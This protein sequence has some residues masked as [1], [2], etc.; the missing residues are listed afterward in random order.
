MERRFRNAHGLRRYFLFL[1]FRLTRIFELYIFNKFERVFVLSEY[2]RSYLLS[3]D[4][5]LKVALLRHSYGAH[6]TNTRYEREDQSLL[7]LGAMDRGP[8]VKSALYF[9]NKIL[10]LVRQDVPDV[11]F[12]I[13]GSR[14]LPEVRALAEKDE[15]TV[16]TG[17]V[18]DIEKYY[19]TATVFVAPLLTGGGIIVKT[20]DAL[21]AG[22]PVV[23]TSIGNEGIGAKPGEHLLVGDTPASFAAQVVLLLCDA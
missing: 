2:D 23:T 18:E 21:A 13:V 5:S 7:F 16:V 1:V 6:L 4:P 22:T 10:P 15:H 12:V 11:K 9:W 20:L 14:P 8:N 17:F 3:I 19:K